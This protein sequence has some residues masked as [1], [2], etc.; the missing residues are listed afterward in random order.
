[1]DDDDALFFTV[2][3][4][5]KAALAPFVK[6]LARVAA[7]RIDT[8][9]YVHKGRFSRAVLAD[10]GVDAAAGHRQIHIIQRPDAREL[11]CDV[12]HFQ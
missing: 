8:A 10:K 3:D 5:G 4:F 7:V 12:L 2:L 11:L 1:M 6:N 9:E